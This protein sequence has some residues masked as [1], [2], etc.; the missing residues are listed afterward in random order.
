M[1]EII[2]NNITSE[3]EETFLYK[4]HLVSKISDYLERINYEYGIIINNSRNNNSI[5][6]EYNSKQVYFTELC[7]KLNILNNELEHINISI[8]LINNNLQFLNYIEKTEV[9][10]II[11]RL[12]VLF[13]DNDNFIEFQSINEDLK[14]YD[15][16][17]FIMLHSMLFNIIDTINHNQKILFS[18]YKNDFREFI[19]ISIITSRMNNLESKINIDSQIK[20]LEKHFNNLN[21]NIPLLLKN[22]KIYLKNISDDSIEITI[23]LR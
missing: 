10:D 21:I 23:K 19:K 17:L 22:Y 9:N 20:E 11:S 3:S 5:F 16:F 8:N 4:K 13:L 14:Y 7:N 12:K 15:K 18:Y 6:K 1:L 2:P